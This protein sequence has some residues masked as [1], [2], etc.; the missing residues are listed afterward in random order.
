MSTNNFNILSFYK[1]KPSGL[2][3]KFFQALFFKVTIILRNFLDISRS[4]LNN[5]KFIT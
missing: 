5:F 1:M 4:F 3:L 2:I